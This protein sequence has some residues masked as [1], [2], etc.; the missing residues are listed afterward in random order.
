MCKI[1]AENDKDV[2]LEPCGHLICHVCLQSWLESGRS[3][4]PFC[5]EDIKDSEAVVVDPFNTRNSSDVPKDDILGT[6]ALATALA[7][8]PG[9][10]GVGMGL[11]GGGGGGGGGGEGGGGTD[12]DCKAVDPMSTVATTTGEEEF[13]VSG[14]GKEGGS[15]CVCVC[16]CVF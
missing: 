10:S 6:Y 14:G 9:M 8:N 1:C 15:V 16:V 5:R 2:K 3:D 4:C 7:L 12:G 11:G 13:E